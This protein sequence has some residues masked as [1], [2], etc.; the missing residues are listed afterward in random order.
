MITIKQIQIPILQKK[1]ISKPTNCGRV[2]LTGN[3]LKIIEN[4][5]IKE[6]IEFQIEEYARQLDKWFEIDEEEI[7]ASR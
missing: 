1:L 5:I 6:N 4:H 3:T 2:T 7:K